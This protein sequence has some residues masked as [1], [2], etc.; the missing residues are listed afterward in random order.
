MTM[1]DPKDDFLDDLFAQ[2]RASEVLPSDALMARV[3]ADADAQLR[4]EIAPDIAPEHGA[5]YGFLQMIGGWPA[6]SGVAA[7]GVAGLWVGLAP[8]STVEGWVADLI[9]TTTQVALMPDFDGFE[10]SEA[11]DG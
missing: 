5:F 9:G 2:A 6:L 7:A 10:F 3:L 11:L 8:P 4:P 1:H